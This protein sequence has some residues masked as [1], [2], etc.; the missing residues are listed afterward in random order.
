M[1]HLFVARVGRPLAKRRISLM[2]M[3]GW[4]ALLSGMAI[5]APQGQKPERALYVSYLHKGR[6]AEALALLGRAIRV[7]ESGQCAA[8]PLHEAVF[9][10]RRAVVEALLKRGA[11]ANAVRCLGW[12]P[13]MDASSSM[14]SSADIVTLLI[15]KGAR[16]N[17]QRFD[18]ETAL[19]LATAQANTTVVLL[20]LDAK[21]D[22]NLRD[23]SGRTPLFYARDGAAARML[24][25][26]GADI[27]LRDKQGR[28]PYD[29]VRET[30]IERMGNGPLRNAASD[31]L[32]SIG[33]PS[34]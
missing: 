24:V 4:L 28:L 19:H 34:R 20:L 6:D 12:T 27:T 32:K 13:I 5:C 30:E 8:T 14:K 22:P 3:A 9:I 11:N 21:A 10:Q 23:A 29:V 7:N 17:A 25:E 18:G 33:A 31:Y 16:V 1:P 2:L 26:A 15:A